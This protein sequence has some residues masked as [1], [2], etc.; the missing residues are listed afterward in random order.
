MKSYQ[1]PDYGVGYAY[2]SSP[3]GPYSK[4][5]SNPILSQDASRSI[6]STGHGSVIGARGSSDPKELY[7]P[8]HARPS[9][10]SDRYL[11]NARLFVNP[12]TLYMGIGSDAGDL[13]LP[14]GVAPVDVSSNSTGNGTWTVSVESKDGV[15]FDLSSP[16]NRL[17]AWVDTGDSSDGNRT[18]VEDVEVEVVGGSVTVR[19]AVPL[20]TTV[21]V[22][23]QRARSN[24]TQPWLN[25]SQAEGLKGGWEA[26]GTTLEL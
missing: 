25:V 11:Y 1:S 21:K 9:A 16:A 6:F 17:L 10:S 8:H 15:A 20:G 2:A 4:S 24:E 19:G 14:S 3:M 13:R 7:Y 23:Y 26:V 12:D 22:V 5:P 18:T